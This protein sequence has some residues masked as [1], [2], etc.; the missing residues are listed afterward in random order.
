MERRAEYLDFD[1]VVSIETRVIPRCTKSLNSYYAWLMAT[2][3]KLKHKHCTI[4][5]LLQ[6]SAASMSDVEHGLMPSLMGPLL[7][8]PHAW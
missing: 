5:L 2:P 8:V 6:Q 3:D 7:H 4:L 1:G